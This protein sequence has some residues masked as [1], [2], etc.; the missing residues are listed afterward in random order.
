MPWY[1]LLRKDADFSLSDCHLQSFE[2]IK[3]EL[4]QASTTNLRLAKPGQQCVILCDAN[5][6]SS[7]F[8]LMIQD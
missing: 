2:T 5:Y 4:L 8:L 1:K 7:G 6:Y 3:E